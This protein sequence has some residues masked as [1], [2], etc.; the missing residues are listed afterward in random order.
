MYKRDPASDYLLSIPLQPGGRLLL[1]FGSTAPVQ[2]SSE[3]L[4]PFDSLGRGPNQT[5]QSEQAVLCVVEEFSKH[6]VFV[7]EPHDREIPCR[8]DGIVKAYAIRIQGAFGV[9]SGTA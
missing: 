5:R 7:V 2:L 3:R 9:H 4:S 1:R 8:F 6:L